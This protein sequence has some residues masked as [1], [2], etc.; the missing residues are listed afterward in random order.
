M[1][2]FRSRKL[3]FFLIGPVLSVAAGYLVGLEFRQGERT[4]IFRNDKNMALYS[5]G[6]Y[7]RS[8]LADSGG[9]LDQD[10][11]RELSSSES[12]P[13]RLLKHYETIGDDGR[14]THGIIELA[15][16]S[17]KGVILAQAAIDDA[18]RMWDETARKNLTVAPLEPISDPPLWHYRINSFGTEGIAI[19]EEMQERLISDVGS[20]SAD[21]LVRA[22]HSENY[23]GNL[24]QHEVHIA[25]YVKESRPADTAM[26]RTYVTTKQLMV[27]YGEINPESGKVVRTAL[28]TPEFVPRWYRDLARF[29]PSP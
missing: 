5:S 24:G 16:L 9:N 6:D 4:R 22:F 15:G 27:D 12:V 2:R 10:R 25:Q 28:L 3:V 17:E 13:D 18:W 23:F 21:I 1:N 29:P 19:W 11:N 26:K 20:Q 7:T 8:A 14:L